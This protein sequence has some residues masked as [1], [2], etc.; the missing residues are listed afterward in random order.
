MA[1]ES[2]LGALDAWITRAPDYAYAEEEDAQPPRWCGVCHARDCDALEEH[3]TCCQHCGEPEHL[4]C[5]HRRPSG[6]PLG[7]CDPGITEASRMCA[8]KGA[9][10]GGVCRERVARRQAARVESMQ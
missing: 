1:L 5:E 8:A 3:C 7:I 10:F 4:G 2:W 6:A 9:H